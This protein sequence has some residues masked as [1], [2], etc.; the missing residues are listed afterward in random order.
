MG[1]YE[2]GSGRIY[3]CGLEYLEDESRY[4]T[5]LRPWLDNFPREQLYVIQVGCRSCWDAVAAGKL[6]WF[7]PAWLVPSEL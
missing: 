4:A 2:R 5:W 6:G 1:C 3:R 7:G